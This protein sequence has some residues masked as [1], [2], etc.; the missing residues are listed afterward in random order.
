MKKFLQSLL[1]AT[2]L[3]VGIGAAPASADMLLLSKLVQ[4][5]VPSYCGTITRQAS[6]ET[7]ELQS[8]LNDSLDINAISLTNE[9]RKSKNGNDI[10]LP[11][12]RFATGGYGYCHIF[13]RHM[14]Y[15]DGDKG[16]KTASNLSQFVYASYPSY[17]MDIA[18]EVINS[19]VT[20]HTAGNG[21]LYKETYSN[22]EGQHVRV[23]Y[24]KTSRWGDRKY[25]AYDYVI[26]SMYPF[27]F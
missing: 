19:G 26:I 3:F 6:S 15:S 18:M 21:N 20:E 27:G 24:Q 9:V 12:P 5:Q 25:D 11:V 22:I 23:V 16:T 7:T 8:E 2:L 4:S 1:V 13:N 17:T 14:K 10:I